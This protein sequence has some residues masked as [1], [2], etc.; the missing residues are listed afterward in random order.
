[1]KPYTGLPEDVV[2]NVIEAVEDIVEDRYLKKFSIGRTGDTEARRSELGAD[3]IVPVYR[4][5]DSDNAVYVEE[6]LLEVFRGNAGYAVEVNNGSSY[7][8]PEGEQY[9]YIAVWLT[10]ETLP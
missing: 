3:D 5:S 8:P 7:G 4:T 6:A 10:D 1:M 2:P 9:V